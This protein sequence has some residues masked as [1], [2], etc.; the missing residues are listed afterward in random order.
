[1]S[2]LRHDDTNSSAEP[3]DQSSLL[4]ND[5]DVESGGLKECV[6]CYNSIEITQGQYMVRLTFSTLEYGYTCFYYIFPIY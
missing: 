3:E 4:Q 2:V 1:M 5:A 6:I